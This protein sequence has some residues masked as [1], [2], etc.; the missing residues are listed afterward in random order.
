[1]NLRE[2]VA[3]ECDM[4]MTGLSREHIPVE[5]YHMAARIIAIIDEEREK[6]R[7]KA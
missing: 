4:W 6:E 2:R 3:R 7:S 5:A 1:M